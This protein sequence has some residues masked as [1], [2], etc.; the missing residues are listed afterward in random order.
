MLADRGRVCF[1]GSPRLRFH[2]LITA[3]QTASK[4]HHHC[5]M[6]AHIS[7]VFCVN[8]FFFFFG[9]IVKLSEFSPARGIFFAGTDQNWKRCAVLV[10]WWLHPQTDVFI[11]VQFCFSVSEMDVKNGGEGCA[12]IYSAIHFIPLRGLDYSG[13]TKVIRIHVIPQI[14]QKKKKALQTAKPCL[15]RAADPCLFTKSAAELRLCLLTGCLI[16]VKLLVRVSDSSCW[17]ATGYL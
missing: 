11:A 7:E 5:K 12:S 3:A 10:F 6:T 14:Q 8:F 1:H 2:R 13:E 4:W 9:E 15:H 16:H 17:W